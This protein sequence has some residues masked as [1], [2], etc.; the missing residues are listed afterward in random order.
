VNITTSVFKKIPAGLLVAALLV[1][2]MESYFYANR[3]HFVKDYWNKFIINEQALVDAPRDYPY[4]IL[5]N[6]TQKT[7]IRASE[8]GPELLC[9]G[10][11]GGKPMAHYLLLCR[12]LQKHPAPKTLFLFVDPGNETDSLLVI[13]RYFV[14]VKEFAMLWPD[15]SWEERRVFLG[16][17]FSTIDLRKVSLTRRAEYPGTNANF[18]ESLLKN[19]G[20]M[21]APPFPEKITPDYF[22]T[23]PRWVPD[24]MH[25]SDR[26]EKYLRKIMGLAKDRGIEVILLPALVPEELA[27][28]PQGAAFLA[29]YDFLRKKIVSDFPGIPP[30]G[31]PSYILPNSYFADPQHV[32]A[33]GS[34]LFTADFARGFL[35]PAVRRHEKP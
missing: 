11:P 7:G 26:D 25:F 13:L 4:V 14:N 35:D 31:E 15:L 2:S 27:R 21:P 34:K 5:G 8:T 6:S 1:V 20:W 24:K 10:L 9:L 16:K 17:Y 3:R 12:Y 23:H 29:Q 22:A 30:P 28:L 33:E 19:H 18:V 32:G